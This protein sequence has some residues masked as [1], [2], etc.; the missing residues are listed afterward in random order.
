[1]APIEVRGR[2]ATAFDTAETLGV[3]PS[4][5]GINKHGV[6]SDRRRPSWHAR[7]TAALSYN[8]KIPVWHIQWGEM[9][10]WRELDLVANERVRGK[11]KDSGA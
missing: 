1:M 6:S 2:F 10:I 11:K 9:D 8:P 3:S 4:R 7:R 5:Q